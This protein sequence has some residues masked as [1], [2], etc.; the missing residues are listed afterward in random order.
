MIALP[1]IS[2]PTRLALFS[3]AALADL[4]LRLWSSRYEVGH[5]LFGGSADLTHTTSFAAET[6]LAVP[7]ASPMLLLSPFA[8]VIGQLLVRPESSYVRLVSLFVIG[9][10]FLAQSSSPILGTFLAFIAYLIL[11]SGMVRQSR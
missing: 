5:V 2:Q 9:G 1:N 8:F 10:S 4:G 7:T 6:G 11:A 3:L